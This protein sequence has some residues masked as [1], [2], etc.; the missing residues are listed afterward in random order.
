MIRDLKKLY[1]LIKDNQV[2][3][4]ATN[5]KSFVGELEKEIPACR[6]YD[7]FYREFKKKRMLQLKGENSEILFAQKVM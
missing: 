2:V 3:M 6:N 5:L 1:V 7:Y 4:F